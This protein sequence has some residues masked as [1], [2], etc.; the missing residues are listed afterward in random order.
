VGTSKKVVARRRKICMP[1]HTPKDMHGRAP[2][3]TDTAGGDARTQTP[4]RSGLA[5]E[6]WCEALHPSMDVF[7]APSS[8]CTPS[9]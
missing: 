4:S 3:S 9:R 8:S 1:K 7:S 2:A 6:Q 5:W